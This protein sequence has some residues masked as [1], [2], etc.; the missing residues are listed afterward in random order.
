MDLEMMQR[1]KDLKHYVESRKD[2]KL[3][4]LTRRELSYIADDL[5]SEYNDLIGSR[6]LVLIS[7]ME[8]NNMGI[9]P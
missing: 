4:G 6:V 7:I 3:T 2:F 8:E 5:Y 9:L 1:I